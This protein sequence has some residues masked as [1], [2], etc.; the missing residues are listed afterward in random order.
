[1]RRVVIDMQNVLF[2]D[3]VAEALRRFDSDF[4]TV[5]SERPDKTLSLCE[6]VLANVLV[7]EVTAYTP[8]KL[9]ERMKIR[10]ELR[11]R[12]PDCKIVLVVDENTEKGLADRVRQAKKD[13][14]VDNFIYGSISSSYLS[15]VI[16]A[17]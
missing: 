17:L 10:D 9:E 6:I 7:M 11:K 8:R 16:D 14:L 5:M 3:A 4:E 15:A 2:A 12:N 1:M 13:G